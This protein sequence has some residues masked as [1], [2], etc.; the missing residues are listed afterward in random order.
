MTLIYKF[1]RQARQQHQGFAL[2]LVL[3]VIALMTIMAA[4]FAQNMRRETL[5]ISNIRDNAQ[6]QAYAEAGLAYTQLMLISGDEELRW[7]GDGGLYQLN[8][9]D[10]QIRVKIFEESGK[11]DINQAE[12]STLNAVFEG[13]TDDELQVGSLVNALL[14]WRD[15]DDEVRAQGA[16]KDQY[17]HQGLNYQPRNKPFQTLEELQ[18]VLGFNA[19]IYNAVEPLLT[20]YSGQKTI[21][22]SKASREVLLTLPEVTP[23]QVDI[24]LQERLENTKNGL[25]APNFPVPIQQAGGDKQIF[26]VVVEALMPTGVKGRIQALIQGGGSNEQP[27]SVSEWGQNFVANESFFQE[28]SDQLLV[29]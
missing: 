19:Q 27:F 23:E 28:H 10:I 5:L 21:N 25:P 2:I 11:I 14:D 6:A 13:V 24:Y 1:Q 29:N 22:P 20:V 18:L 12:E 17:L 9:N 7:R 4:S 15:N 3:W 8:Y 16:E 26:T